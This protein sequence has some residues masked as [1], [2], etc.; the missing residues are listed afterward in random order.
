MLTPEQRSK[1]VQGQAYCQQLEAIDVHEA[2]GSCPGTR[3]CMPIAHGTPARGTR[4]R[5]DYEM[6]GNSL[7][8]EPAR[9]KLRFDHGERF[10]GTLESLELGARRDAMP[11]SGLDREA[12]AEAVSYEA[13]QVALPRLQMPYAPGASEIISVGLHSCPRTVEDKSAVSVRARS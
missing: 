12:T 9:K 4:I 5:G 1:A 8:R 13:I 2:L 7:E 11:T 6:P 3:G 10:G